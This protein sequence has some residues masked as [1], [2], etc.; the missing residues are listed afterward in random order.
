MNLLLWSGRPLKTWELK[1]SH[2]KVQ[3]NDGR[4]SAKTG[5][6]SKAGKMYSA[7]LLQASI[8]VAALFRSVPANKNH[9]QIKTRPTILRVVTCKCPSGLFQACKFCFVTFSHFPL[10]N[11][12]DIPHEI[13][14][15]F[16]RQ[17]GCSI[18]DRAGVRL[19]GQ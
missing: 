9:S 4:E 2:I 10:P 3:R 18:V 1:R 15:S 12:G 13:L 6:F 17:Y 16:S 7:S 14:N 5:S 19:G 11:M 8:V